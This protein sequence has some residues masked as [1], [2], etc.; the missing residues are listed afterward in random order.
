[1]IS[2]RRARFDTWVALAGG[3]VALGCL[4]AVAWH[5]T[6]KPA[7]YPV[8]GALAALLALAGGGAAVAYLA[9]RG[10][11]RDAVRELLGGVTGAADAIGRAVV[12][13]QRE[14][15][16][17]DGELNPLTAPIPDTRFSDIAG[18]DAV[19]AELAELV[20]YLRCPALARSTGIDPPRHVLLVG[21][22]G[23][24]KTLFA[25]AVARAAG[26]EVHYASG[27]EFVQLYVGV[28]A[29]RVRQLFDRAG[30]GP[31]LIFIDELDALARR[32]SGDITG[33]TQEHDNTLN[34]LLTRLDGF[35]TR[36]DK[37]LVFVGATNREDVIDPAL[38]QRMHRRVVVPLPGTADRAAILRLYADRRKLAW[39]PQE[40]QE[41][42]AQ[43]AGFAGRQ[44]ANLIDEAGRQA[45]ARFAHE[46]YELC[47]RYPEGDADL[48]FSLPRH[49]PGRA[50]L[51]PCGGRCA[52]NATVEVTLL[53]AGRAAER[54]TFRDD[55]GTGVWCGVIHLPPG[56]YAVQW[57]VNKAA[58]PEFTF[59]VTEGDPPVSYADVGLALRRVG[60]Y[61]PRAADAATWGDGI[62][63]Y[64]EAADPAKQA[65]ARAAA[66][67]YAGVRVALERP[68]A[69]CPRQLLVVSGPAGSGKTTLARGLA[70]S[71]GVPFAACD[72][73]TVVAARDGA[74]GLVRRLVRAAGDDANRAQ[75]GVLCVES[76]DRPARPTAD[77]GWEWLAQP[78]MSELFEG[79]PLELPSATPLGEP[80]VVETKGILLVIEASRPPG[81]AGGRSV[82][83]WPPVLLNRVAAAT[84]TEYLTAAAWKEVLS[85]PEPKNPLLRVEPMWEALGLSPRPTPDGLRALAE[86]LAEVQGMPNGVDGVLGRLTAWLLTNAPPGREFPVTT[87]VVGTAFDRQ[88]AAP[89]P[90]PA[91]PSRTRNQD[92]VIADLLDDSE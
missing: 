56:K 9:A 49:G 91:A 58:R 54:F 76:A 7:D 80:T 46:A 61:L 28:G 24:G 68:G 62:G 5:L 84:A 40:L 1:M 2:P 65:C 10:S 4:V 32:R 33:R 51:I 22:P 73:A 20:Q 48:E 71:L 35:V 11:R 21:P 45:V 8:T 78:G 74:F 47:R 69:D 92:Q 67:H 50:G 90:P 85:T 38:L 19:K 75:Y 34:E 70:A 83:G 88:T 39:T 79:R 89:P 72:A 14:E 12:R 43:T 3:A 87:A 41:T 26:A 17:D 16:D 59:E 60:T 66:L 36:K 13:A 25:R 23:T 55:H 27:A 44:L 18:Y 86:M 42:A 57:A 30:D 53:A 6:Q 81:T 63:R 52:P 64:A 31:A 82:A 15:A 29:A 37:P 77:G